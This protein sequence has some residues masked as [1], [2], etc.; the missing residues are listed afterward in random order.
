MGR[1]YKDKEKTT[2]ESFKVLRANLSQ[3]VK[4]L[5]E[6][7]ALT[8]LELVNLAELMRPALLS[9]IERNVNT[10]NPTLETLCRLAEALEVEVVKLLS[11]PRKT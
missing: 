6:K 10:V 2:P 7:K 1:K 5:R 4:M 9:D 8:Q 3:N 11:P